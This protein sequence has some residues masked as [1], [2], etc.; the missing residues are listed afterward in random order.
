MSPVEQYESYISTY[1][2]LIYSK[3]ALKLGVYQAHVE[4]LEREPYDMNRA[5]PLMPLMVESIQIDCVMTVSKLIEHG[6]GDRTFQKFLAFVE[7]NMKAISKVYPEIEM[8][9][10]NEQR[11][12]LKEV[13]SQV[14]SILTQRDKYFAHADKKYFFDQNKITDDFPETYN[15]LI[16]ILRA[17][18]RIVGKHQQLMT[19]AHPMCMAEFAYAFSDRTLNHVKVAEKEWHATYRQGEEW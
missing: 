5:N 12:A 18:Q 4:A 9:L 7:R 6:R 15:E 14:S 16:Q 1:S 13:E 10:V 19:G 2:D 3:V 11:Q 17:L 8:S